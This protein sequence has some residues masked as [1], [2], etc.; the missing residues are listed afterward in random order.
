MDNRELFV[1]KKDG[2]KEKFDL[3]KVVNAVKK[4]ARR[5]L[6][7]FTPEQIENICFIVKNEVENTGRDEVYIQ[8]MHNIV[9]E[10]LEGVNPKVGQSYRNYRNYK[11]DFVRMLDK[12]YQESQKIMYVGDKENS[13]SDSALVSTKRS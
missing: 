5:V 10:A 2:T 6:I 3:E 1:I 12:V 7:D 13:N 8:D 9:E 4:S 11:Q